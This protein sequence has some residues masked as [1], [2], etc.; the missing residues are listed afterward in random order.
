MRGINLIKLISSAHHK[1]S[2]FLL[3]IIIRV[4]KIR[5][6]VVIVGNIRDMMGC[7]KD[8]MELNHQLKV[9]SFYFYQKS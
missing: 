1:N 8:L 4:L 6:V 5:I 3:D 9:R 7:I 2:Q